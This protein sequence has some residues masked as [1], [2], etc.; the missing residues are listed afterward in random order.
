MGLL[1]DRLRLQ[2]D[3]LQALDER[4]AELTN[5]LLEK[6]TTAKNS[7]GELLEETE[8]LTEG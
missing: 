6:V 1:A 3:K 5:Q 4:Q 7:L 8:D 2:L